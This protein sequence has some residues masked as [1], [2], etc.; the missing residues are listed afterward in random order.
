VLVLAA[1]AFSRP[2]WLPRAV[3]A[4]SAAGMLAFAISDPDHRIADHNVDRFEHTGRIDTSVLENLSAD[5]APALMRLP[6][7]L[8]SCTTAPM[9]RELA[10]PD[11]LAGLNAGRARARRALRVQG[12]PV[13]QPCS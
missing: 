3:V 11:G 7:Y 13:G 4:L 6:G 8:R 1:G 2:R 10:A 5:A 9:R 12:P